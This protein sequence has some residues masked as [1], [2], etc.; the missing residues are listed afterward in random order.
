MST[1]SRAARVKLPQFAA[2][3]CSTAD[4]SKPSVAELLLAHQHLKRL[5]NKVQKRLNTLTVPVWRRV[6]MNSHMLALRAARIA[7]QGHARDE[8]MHYF[9]KG[10]RLASDAVSLQWHV[11]AT[12]IWHV[13]KYWKQ[14]S[15]L[16]AGEGLAARCVAQCK[17]SVAPTVTAQ[18]MQIRESGS[19]KLTLDVWQLHYIL[20]ESN[21]ASPSSRYPPDFIKEMGADCFDADGYMTAQAVKRHPDIL[22][23][24]D[25]LPMTESESSTLLHRPAISRAVH[26]AMDQQ[27]LHWYGH[28]MLQMWRSRERAADA[29][30]RV[31]TIPLH[32]LDTDE[33]DALAN[34]S[35][36]LSSDGNGPASPAEDPLEVTMC[37]QSDS[38]SIQTNVLAVELPIWYLRKGSS[39]DPLFRHSDAEIN[40][41][42][43]L[44]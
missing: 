29:K 38:S 7:K 33:L 22:T 18:A 2:A 9:V 34:A 43:Y 6:P 10:L 19:E 5:V 12:D 23:A 31:P 30:R 27:Q 15:A 35:S 28:K 25:I 17:S 32:L 20:I 36:V 1:R 40:T 41:P 3:A 8:P 11:T 13:F 37:D 24:S 21:R 4:E 14:R 16:E 42:R 26:Y 39:R 44:E